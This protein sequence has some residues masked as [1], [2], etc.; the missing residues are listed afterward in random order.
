MA[1]LLQD[2]DFHETDP[3]AHEV[4]L[5]CNFGTTEEEIA[6]FVNAAKALV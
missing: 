2:F 4:R 6:A 3:V 1:R 5:M